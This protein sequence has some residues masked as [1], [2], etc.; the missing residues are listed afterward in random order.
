M[1]LDELL[2]RSAPPICARGP[3]MHEELGRLVRDSETAAGRR[4][5]SVRLGVAG[6]A[7]AAVVG[8]APVAS[9]AGLLPGWAEWSTTQGSSCEIQLDA[10]LRRDG[11]GEL[12]TKT[13]SDAEQRAT[14]A[15]AQEFLTEFDYDS[16]DRDEAIAEWQAQEARIRAGQRPDER[17]PALRGDDLEVTAVL[18][19]VVNRLRDYLQQRGLDI[20]AVMVSSGNRCTR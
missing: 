8:L 6:V 14:Y 16:V 4:R 5:R 13:F 1:D 15:A 18:T 11:D 10:S 7:V 12:I 3:R 20:R 2:E 17:Q 9:A 19:Q